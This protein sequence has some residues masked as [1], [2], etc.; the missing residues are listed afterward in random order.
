MW[1]TIEYWSNHV[2]AELQASLDWTLL[3][4]IVEIVHERG[5]KAQNMLK[6]VD[7]YVN[8]Y[9]LKDL[10]RWCSMSTTPSAL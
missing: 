9:H 6:C 5:A 3:P 1:V 2:R 4:P 10:D 7:E 8:S